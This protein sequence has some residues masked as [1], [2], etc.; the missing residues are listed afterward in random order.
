MN[1]YRKLA[2]DTRTMNSFRTDATSLIDRYIYTKEALHPF[3]VLLCCSF[4]FFLVSLFYDKSINFVI[5]EAFLIASMPFNVSHMDKL[6]SPTGLAS[7]L[8]ASSAFIN[9]FLVLPRSS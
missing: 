3:Q 5:A 2:K 7:C 1:S 8:L 4:V 6:P 9:G